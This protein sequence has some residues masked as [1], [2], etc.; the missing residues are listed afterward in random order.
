MEELKRAAAEKAVELIEEGMVVGLGTG[1]TVSYAIKKIEKIEKRITGIPTSIATK[2]LAES[3]GIKIGSIEDFDVIDIDIDGADEIDGMLNMS[4]GL[5]GAL[6]REKVVA[7]MSRTFVVVADE[8][9]LVGSLGE[10]APVSVELLPF[11]YR[12]AMRELESL[13]CRC[14]LRDVKSDNG[15]LLVSCYFEHLQKQK[16]VA[17]RIKSIT[18]VVEHG[19]F[20]N[21]A[22]MAFIGKRD[23]VMVM[24]R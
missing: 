8:S 13:G 23:G 11:G 2:N 15:N 20:L 6:Y 16:M 22:T 12:R 5:G 19:L 21:M 1:S 7:L 18:G 24:E 3:C 9:K 4:K 10:K 14:V 17:S